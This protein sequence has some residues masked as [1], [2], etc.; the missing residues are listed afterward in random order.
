MILLARVSSICAGSDPL[1][2]AVKP[3][4]GVDPDWRLGAPST[5]TVDGISTAF[6][7]SFS[8]SPQQLSTCQRTE[9]P[10]RRSRSSLSTLL[11][12]KNSILRPI[13]VLGPLR[14]DGS[15][16]PLRGHFNNQLSLQLTSASLLLSEMPLCLPTVLALTLSPTSYLVRSSL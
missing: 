13:A 16:Q 2:E 15:L 14:Y 1:L 5:G 10:Y 6:L 7:S 8:P 9:R 11:Q 4:A 12:Q 3:I